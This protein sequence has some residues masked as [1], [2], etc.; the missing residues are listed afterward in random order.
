LLWRYDE[1]AQDRYSY[2]LVWYSTVFAL[3][4]S[5]LACFMIGYLGWGF[6]LLFSVG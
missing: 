3:G 2:T 6:G 4:F 5:C 1:Y